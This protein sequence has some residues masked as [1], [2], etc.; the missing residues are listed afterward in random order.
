M[1][2]V[3]RQSQVGEADLLV[4]APSGHANGGIELRVNFGL[5]AGREATPAELGDLGRELLA[6]FPYVSIVSE[7]RY[8]MG[9]DAEAAIHQVRVVIAS[10]LVPNGDRE[11]DELRGRLLELA[12]R[13]AQSC[14]AVR[15]EELIE[16]LGD[17]RPGT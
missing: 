12:E 17:L 16:E 11:R 2:E 15:H 8:E 7:R 3:A 4:F 6:R 5:F 1:V 10:E 13:W 9:T 14:I